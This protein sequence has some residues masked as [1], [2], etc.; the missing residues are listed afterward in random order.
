MQEQQ[1]AKPDADTRMGGWVGV[2]YDELEV[3]RH[4][5]PQAMPL[6]AE[7]VACFYRCLGEDRKPEAGMR[8]PAFLLNELRALKSQMRLP[9]G[10]LHA[11]EE[12]TMLSAARVGE[13][14]QTAVRIADKYIRN[15][16]RFVVV[17]QVVTC[18]TD[19]RSILNVRHILYWP[20]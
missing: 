20:C 9:P 15:E 13:P 1:S 19:N 12:L 8:I 3:G 11:Q 14:L 7:D 18:A 10:V 6:S 5:P 2:G 16:K 17:E 4:F